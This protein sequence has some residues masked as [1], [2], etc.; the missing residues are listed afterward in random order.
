MNENISRLMDG[1]LDDAAEFD[2]CVSRSCAPRTRCASWVCYHVIGDHLRGDRGLTQGFAA[3]LS[4]TLADEPTVLAPSVRPARDAQPR[5]VRLGRGGHTRRRH[6]GRLDRLLDGRRPADGGRQGTRGRRPC[7][8]PTSRPGDQVPAELPAGAPGVLAGHG[9]PGRWA[10]S[11]RAASATGGRTCASDAIPRD[12]AARFGS[13]A[14]R[15]AARRAGSLLVDGDAR[16]APVAA[17]QDAVAVAHP[18][19]QRRAHAQLHRYDR[20]PVWRSHRDVAPRP[21]ERCRPGV[22]K[23]DEP[24]RA[25]RARWCATAAKCAATSPT[26]RSSASSRARSA[27]CSRRCRRSRSATCPSTTISAGFRANASPGT[28]RKSWC[29]NRATAL[30]YGHRFWADPGTGL[31]LKARL[32]NE[33]GET[34]EQFAF[35]DVAVNAKIDRDMVKPTWA[36]LPPDWQV[37]QG[38]ERRIRVPTTPAGS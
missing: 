21:S 7:E 18:R 23:A 17:A 9:D 10:P 1:E 35:T 15:C 2:H 30:R 11:L 5:H 19:R 12:E 14:P 29:S 3:R 4:T 26:Q 6:R 28:R 16:A 32:V 25:A 34:V 22:G 20:Q 38:V 13:A 37:T 27:T 36:P 33:K 8:R 24:R 31:L